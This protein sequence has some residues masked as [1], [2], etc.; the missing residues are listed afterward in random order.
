MTAIKSKPFKAR[1][2]DRRIFESSGEMGV[3]KIA[4]RPVTEPSCFELKSDARAKQAR[5][6]MNNNNNN[7]DHDDSTVVHPSTAFKARPLPAF[8]T[9]K[10][11]I[12]VLPIPACKA[13]FKVS[14]Y[15]NLSLKHTHTHMHS[16]SLSLFLCFSL[17]I[18]HICILTID[19]I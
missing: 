3:P 2:L 15:Q 10:S 5:I 18:T 13:D 19:S 6:H 12:P 4:A 8:V 14:C 9:D 7:I 17:I 11:K 16:V 1:L